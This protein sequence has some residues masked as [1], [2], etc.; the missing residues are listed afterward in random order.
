MK[1]IFLILVLMIL[2]QSLLINKS[3][4]QWSLRENTEDG[5]YS[6]I[7]NTGNYFGISA[8][9][10]LSDAVLMLTPSDT[11]VWRLVSNTENGRYSLVE[12]KTMFMGIDSGKIRTKA[13]YI[14]N[15]STLTS[16]GL[17]TNNLA[18]INKSNSFIGR[19]QTF[20]TVNA[21]VRYLLNGVSINT[22]GTLSNVAYQNQSNSFIGRKQLFDTVNATVKYLLNGTDINTAGTLT[23]VA[24]LNQ[25]N[26]F[27]GN[28]II[29]PGSLTGSTSTS[30]INVSQTWNTS[31]TPTGIKLNVT[32]SA[33][34]SASMVM[35]LQVNSTSVFKVDK[36][37]GV[38]IGQNIFTN[39]VQ[40]RNTGASTVW[41]LGTGSIIGLNLRP[42]SNVSITS[43]TSEIVDVNG[44]FAAGTGSANFRPLN[45]SYTINNSGVQSGTATGI[46]LNATETSLNSM[47]HNL[48][49]LQLNSS[50][51][52][53]V[54]RDGRLTASTVISQSDITAGPNNGITFT[55][56]TQLS[57][58]SAGNLLV[59]NTTGGTGATINAGTHL[60]T[61]LNTFSLGSASLYY[62]T[63]FTNNVSIRDTTITSSTTVTASFPGKILI[64]A[65]GG[66]VTLTFPN[67]ATLRNYN[68]KIKRIDN[69]GNT[70]T[71]S[72][73]GTIDD[74][75]TKSVS[76][77]S[78]YTVSCTASGV[79]K[80]F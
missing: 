53:S 9:G 11:N 12:N 55:G 18:Y 76:Y 30:S 44:T 67:D 34:N 43:G 64:D 46:F 4:A 29:N 35:D 20:D 74:A 14:L 15:P 66:N 56:R 5:K 28:I 63:A 52:F 49:D 2:C 61:V 73:A 75:G 47:N 72:T 45:I 60:P 25:P 22:A 27:S 40:A 58:P 42:I 8:G 41:N 37:G 6:L 32:D 51:V 36:V 31:G 19:K 21:S 69:T 70:V 38:T 65:T 71:L 57:A 50:S 17:D 78:A 68:Y 39:N 48:M 3:D 62:T 24:Y 26:S 7:T 13:V 1:K 33:S 59:V 79:Y 23:N 54:R 80:L 10:I 16:L 77:N